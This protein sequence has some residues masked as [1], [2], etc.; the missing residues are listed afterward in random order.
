MRHR[1]LLAMCALLAVATSGCDKIQSILGRKPK[2]TA[3]PAAPARPPDTLPTA[4][5]AAPTPPPA[6][7]VAVKP[8]EDVPYDSPDTG[9][10]NPGM[11]ERDV[12]ALWGPPAAVRRANEYTYLYFRN[13]CEKTCG[14]MDLVILQNGQVVDAVVRWPGHGY[15]GESSSPPGRAPFPTRGGDTLTVPTVPER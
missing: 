1:T 7:P 8:V 3:P 10:V 13:G 12:Y 5:V 4:P 11:A 14:T 15:S 6:P 2:T 9:T